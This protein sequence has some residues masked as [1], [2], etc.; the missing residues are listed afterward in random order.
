MTRYCTVSRSLNKTLFALL[1]FSAASG[2]AAFR[3]EED[4]HLVRDV[5][6]VF[7][8]ECTLRGA[9]EGDILKRLEIA[10]D[11]ARRISDGEVLKCFETNFS[12]ISAVYSLYRKICNE[13]SQNPE[14]PADPVMGRQL[15]EVSKYQSGV[16]PYHSSLNDCLV[17]IPDRKGQWAVVPLTGAELDVRALQ[18]QIDE[19]KVKQPFPAT[20]EPFR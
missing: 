3:S 10:S 14:K 16:R 17:N 9:A 20:F 6:K 18:K 1:L 11:R 13:V 7:G 5:L 4:R 8:R 12:Q 19:I 2:Q 15:I